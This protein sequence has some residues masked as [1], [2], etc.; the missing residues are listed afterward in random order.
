MSQ[1]RLNESE[2]NEEKYPASTKKN[3]DFNIK[4]GVFRSY[5]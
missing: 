3:P 4:K 5:I 1:K 2:V